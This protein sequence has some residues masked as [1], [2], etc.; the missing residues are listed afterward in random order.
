MPAL[1]A[2]GPL[3]LAVACGLVACGPTRMGSPNAVMRAYATA[4]IDG[5]ADAAYAMLSDEAK[6]G[7]SPDAFAEILRKY[8]QEALEIGHS[9]A[10]PTGDPYVTATVTLA[11]GE[12]I[13]MVLEEGVWHV[14]GAAIDFYSQSSPRQAIAGFARAFQRKRFDVLLRYTPDAHLDG[15]TE[16]RLQ[17][18]WGEGKPEGKK[19]ADKLDVISS[20]LATAKIEEV[21]DR[22]TVDYESGIVTLVREHG[23]WKIEDL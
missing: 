11:N 19:V 1:R 14:D 16:A 3:A 15:L 6:K 2:A 12:T 20:K 9:L 22:A 21:G 8:P 18:A 13:A 4:V 7:M 5:R 23:A 17:A 10:R